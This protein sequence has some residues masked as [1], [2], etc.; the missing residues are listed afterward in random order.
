MHNRGGGGNGVQHYKLQ[1]PV[2]SANY[3][4]D[5]VERHQEQLGGGGGRPPYVRYRSAHNPDWQLGFNGRRVSRTRSGLSASLPRRMHPIK[6]EKEGWWTSTTNWASGK[7]EE[8]NE[9]KAKKRQKRRRRGK[10]DFEFSIGEFQKKALEL[11]WKGI[12]EHIKLSE[13]E[14]RLLLLKTA[15]E[16]SAVVGAAEKVFHENINRLEE[17]LIRPKQSS[18]KDR[19]I[20]NSN[21]DENNNNNNSPQS[22]S[23]R[24]VKK[25][26]KLSKKNPQQNRRRKTR[27]N[28]GTQ[29]STSPTLTAKLARPQKP[30][31]KYLY[32]D[33]RLRNSKNNSGSQSRRGSSRRRKKPLRSRDG[34]MRRRMISS[35]SAADDGGYP[36]SFS[37]AAR[38]P[39]MRKISSSSSGSGNGRSM[40]RKRLGS[41]EKKSY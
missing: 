8:E 3:L 6:D 31:G 5:V 18:Q 40:R 25:K 35:S 13:E 26:K 20:N 12:F 33:R 38:R 9:E 41:R 37:E 4:Q 29:I 17:G 15:T 22:E 32:Y 23:V 10:C 2:V 30:A 7:E 11:E 16:A 36:S 21:D 1:E 39:R 19:N 24:K 28:S 34:R 27:P 14:E